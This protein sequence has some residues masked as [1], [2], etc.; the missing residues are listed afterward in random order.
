MKK[1]KLVIAA[2]LAAICAFAQTTTLANFD[3]NGSPAYPI[4]AAVTAN[5]ITA[6]VDG[7]HTN[8]AY[9]GVATG[10]MAFNQNTTAGN[11]LAMSNSSGTNT[12]YWTLTLGGGSLSTYQSYML[13]FQSEHSNT[14][15]TTINISYSTDGITFNALGQSVSPGLNTTYTEAI[16]D[17]SSITAI[18]NASAVY[19]RFAASGASGNGTLR[20]DNLQVIGSAS[21]STGSLSSQWTPVGSN[22]RFMGN[23]GIGNF[24]PL[25]PLDVKGDTHVTGNLTVDGVT[26]LNKDLYAPTFYLGNQTNN[27]PFASTSTSTGAKILTIGGIPAQTVVPPCIPN[28][29]GAGIFQQ[30]RVI[31]T[32]GLANGVNMLDMRNDGTNGY[33]EFAHNSSGNPQNFIASQSN[34]SW[35][36]LKI[37]SACNGNV[38]IGLGGGYVSTSNYFE[39]GG[40]VRNA[41]ITSNIFAASTR[42]GQRVTTNH[43]NIP[44]TT[45][46]NTQLFVNRPTTH[47]LSVFNTATNTN[48]DENFVVYG[49]GSTAIG[50]TYV[51]SGYKLAVNG[52]AIA[53]EVVVELPAN[54]PDYV[55]KKD[56]TL[57]PLAELDRFVKKE[58]HLPEVPSAEQVE[59]SGIELA[60]MNTVLLKKVEE[61]TLYIIELDKAVAAL[62]KQSH[63]K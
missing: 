22:L 9:A 2:Q 46:Y 27:I 23:V 37:N 49:D 47:A 45:Y 26:L 32:T 51:P 19:L 3:F 57:L 39:A 8:A 54:W 24:N 59:K 61:L 25:V 11:S 52:L 21:A 7:T 40:P 16:V 30:S 48:G 20:M 56:Y 18:N 63:N 10:T 60:K 29:S 50:G 28:L 41:L 62:K 58:N 4:S 15:A 1:I 14:G 38:E 35:P 55:F 17:L 44:N 12:H 53:Q 43:A 31:V 13:Y 6:S 42:I 34:P 5:G 33:I 36:T